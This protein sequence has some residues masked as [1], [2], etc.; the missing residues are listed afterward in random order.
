MGTD[1]DIP[2]NNHLFRMKGFFVERGKNLQYICI[3]IIILL[4]ILEFSS[5][6]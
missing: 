4:K 6:D 1:Y 3:N 2:T 5:F